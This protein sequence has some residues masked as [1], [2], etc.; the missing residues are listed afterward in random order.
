[1]SLLLYQEE[2]HTCHCYLHLAKV[3]SNLTQ[4]HEMIGYYNVSG[5]GLFLLPLMTGKIACLMSNVQTDCGEM[6]KKRGLHVGIAKDEIV[7]CVEAV[8]RKNGWPMA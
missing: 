3:P 7:R 5:I 6:I 1:M 2:V 8:A 4:E